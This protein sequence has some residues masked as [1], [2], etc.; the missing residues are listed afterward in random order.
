MQTVTKF[1]L[2]IFVFLLG[3]LGCASVTK[4]IVDFEN[5]KTISSFENTASAQVASVKQTLK[6]YLAT[7]SGLKAFFDA[8]NYISR[9]EFSALT[10]PYMATH[11]SV[12]ALGWIPIVEDANRASLELKAKF[13]GVN[14]FKFR[15]LDGFGSLMPATSREIYYPAFYL[16]PSKNSEVEIGFDFG[17]NEIG[18]TALSMA[19]DSAAAA[20]MGPARS[21]GREHG[22]APVVLFMAIYNKSY[23]KASILSR[24]SASKR[25]G[26]IGFGMLSFNLEKMLFELTKES[27]CVVLVDD[28]TNS[29]RS[30]SLYAPHDKINA[31]LGV[32]VTKDI[33]FAGRVWRITVYPE[34]GSYVLN[35]GPLLWFALL[36]G[37]LSTVLLTYY[38]VQMIKREEIIS[39]KVNLK[40]IELADSEYKA[41]MIL[42]TAVEAII[43][44]NS[45]G[46]IYSLNKSA[47]ALFGYQG[48]DVLGQSY[49]QLITSGMP[50]ATECFNTVI[51]A[52]EETLEVACVKKDGSKFD[53]ELTHSKFYLAGETL[54][55]LFLRDISQRKEAELERESLIERL[56]ESNDDLS[57]FAYVA[58][59]DLQ[60]PLRMVYNFTALLEQEY[61]EALDETAHQYMTISR[62]AAQRMQTLVADLLTYSKVGTGTDV[63][64]VIDSAQVVKYIQQNLSDNIE[65]TG[66][67][68]RCGA[69]PEVVSNASQFT[70]LM[71]NL[72]SNSV[73][74]RKPNQSPV[75]DVT[76]EISG[77]NWRF[78]VKDNGIGIEEKYFELVF[79][80]FKR[81]H[82][83]KEF[84]GTGIGL[85]ICAKIVSKLDGRIWVESD[86]GKGTTISFE[87]PRLSD[88]DILS[89]KNK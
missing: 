41:N 26:V 72:I 86:Y 40:T 85:A 13:D 21:I 50:T 57:R 27:K 67:V 46:C 12:Q 51:G 48:S 6:S 36:L 7:L 18:L 60:E 38:L 25:Q 49:R 65:K 15:Q 42:E 69:L 87:I 45:R 19:I 24:S 23:M 80:P 11:E 84:K 83:Q 64:E 39:E 70:S 79:Q 66:A 59:H 1:K 63:S 53:G 44:V 34:E 17:S 2:P 20:A 33:R 55:S 52:L 58:S 43:T 8:S 76:G 30:V 16:T 78:T 28:V 32:S 31:A 9:Q 22:H 56:N 62:D 37:F 81:L 29:S 82:T 4:I 73:K 88:N 74:Y 71:Q 75:V 5:E 47:R 89:E 68:I 3:C 14:E 54:H 10:S 35:S 77:D 61:G